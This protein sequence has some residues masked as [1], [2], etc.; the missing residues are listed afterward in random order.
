MLEQLCHELLTTDTASDLMTMKDGK[1]YVV[2]FASTTDIK[3]TRENHLTRLHSAVIVANATAG[4]F[5]TTRGFTRDA[6]AYAATAPIKLV[7]GPKLIASIKRGMAGS[8]A[9]DSYK[10]MCRQ[11]GEIVTHKLDRGEA[12]PCSNGHSVAPTIARAALVIQ[13]RDDG[14]TSRTYTQPRQFTRREV[15]AHNSKYIARMK[16]RKPGVKNEPPATGPEIMPEPG[17]EHDAEF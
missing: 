13:K 2:A 3:P 14:S 1:K 17:A 10:A 9:P 15:N 12:V 5:I 11:C 4:F 16:R 6:E 8:A 7:D